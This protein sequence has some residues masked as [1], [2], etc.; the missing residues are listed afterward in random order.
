MLFKYRISGRE[1]FT[2]SAL[3]REVIRGK[4]IGWR[5][6]DQFG[7]CLFGLQVNGRSDK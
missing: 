3:T 1:I 4:A 5:Q 6:K 2:Q 7:F